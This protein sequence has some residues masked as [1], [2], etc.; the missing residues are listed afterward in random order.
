LS[1]DG[2]GEILYTHGM[3]D[4]VLT[5]RIPLAPGDL[6]GAKELSVSA[7]SPPQFSIRSLLILQVLVALFFGVFLLAGFFII[8]LLML[9]AL[10]VALIRVQPEYARTKRLALEFICGIV[11]PV[12]CLIYDPFYF[13]PAFSPTRHRDVLVEFAILVIFYQMAFFAVWLLGQWWFRRWAM[14]FSGTFIVGCICAAVTGIVI[15][16]LTFVG[17]IM[18]G[19]GLPGWTPWLTFWAFYSNAR[20]AYRRSDSCASRRERLLLGLAGFFLALGIPGLIYFF[21]GDWLY[22][23][24]ASPSWH[25]NIEFFK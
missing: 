9:I 5:D 15:F 22:G 2:S 10:L 24:L 19:F 16:P 6:P 17:T 14:F 18:L 12:L 1:L 20:K 11:L 13:H 4:R 23:N 21:A 8:H 25:K 3:S 7:E